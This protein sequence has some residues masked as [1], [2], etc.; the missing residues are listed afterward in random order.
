M[1]GN[2]AHRWLAI[3]VAQGWMIFALQYA[4]LS[5]VISSAGGIG[6]LPWLFLGHAII[7]Y[8]FG[9]FVRRGDLSALR[10]QWV[11]LGVLSLVLC[12]AERQIDTSSLS[13]PQ[14]AAFYL[15]GQV[16][17]SFLRT[18]SQL[19][20]ATR[21]PQ[22]GSSGGATRLAMAEETGFL[23]GS[24]ALL[25]EQFLGLTW[26]PW[27][28]AA[29]GVVGLVFVAR[30]R[31]AL[32]SAPTLGLALDQGVEAPRFRKALLWSFGAMA[33]L[34][35]I[36]AYGFAQGL[37]ELSSTQVSLA[38][39]FSSLAFLQ[40]VATLGTLAWVASTRSAPTWFR[41]I[42]AVPLHAGVV[43][44]AALLF[45]FA[46]LEIF[47][48]L[49]CLG[50]V[51]RK[52]FEHGFYSRSMGLLVA[53]LP[54]RDRT[55]VR[56]GIER[57]AVPLGLAV[58]GFLCGILSEQGS[59]NW[60]LWLTG[61]LI[62]ILAYRLLR[63]NLRQVGHYH[64]SLVSSKDLES[65]ITAIQSLGTP[66]YVAYSSALVRVLATK[67]RPVLTKNLLL[68]LGRTGDARHTSAMAAFLRDGREDIQT[69]AATALGMLPGHEGNLE[70]LRMLRELVRSRQ[71]P[72]LSMVRAL[73]RKLGEL[74]IPYLIEV[75]TEDSDPRVKANTIEV[76]GE[77]ASRERDLSLLEF[78]SKFLDPSHSRR[79][80]INAAIALYRRTPWSAQAEQVILEFIASPDPL[81]R[82]GAVFAIGVLKLRHF[83]SLLVDICEDCE[84]RHKNALLSLVRIG[85][86]GALRRAVQSLTSLDDPDFAK[87][88]VLGLSF[89]EPS[90]RRRLWDELLRIAPDGLDLVQARLRASQ[91]E[92]DVDREWLRDA[93]AYSEPSPNKKAA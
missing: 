47:A 30:S 66:D 44:V 71:E 81:D 12:L 9:S 53:G 10:R 2:I 65:Q 31:V 90:E 69:A 1:R 16:L 40:S 86:R 14:I 33:A 54:V 28:W 92:F 23:L 51:T 74:S 61:A 58:A 22:L 7:A 64:M 19:F 42:R 18:T 59:R 38:W 6:I 50:E 73:M 41:G 62:A 55:L 70:L 82:S 32:R 87:K 72:R 20:Y 25:A 3:S 52:V 75:L 46:K 5:L 91:R 37:H 4:A 43:F 89:L 63:L 29:P 36:L 56:R 48:T 27:I 77:Y 26:G 85:H 49:L 39:L 21:L 80:R 60:P 67:P 78:L 11:T 34:K 17:I 68:A 84:W 57:W 93:D 8:V 35:W 45:T 76:M 13:L 24:G 15:A 88:L 79:E 83:E